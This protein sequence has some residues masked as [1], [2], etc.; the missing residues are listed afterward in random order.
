MSQSTAIQKTDQNKIL[1]E[2]MT[3]KEATQLGLD[4]WKCGRDLAMRLF[5]VYAELKSIGVEEETLQMR[6][7]GGAIALNDLTE[8][9]ALE[10]IKVLNHWLNSY[11]EIVREATI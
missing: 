3:P 7:A 4:Q 8:A 5:S 9:Q 10:A 6:F 11:K 2:V 1:S